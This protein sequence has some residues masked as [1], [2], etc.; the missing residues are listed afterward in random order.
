M[1]WEQGT[2]QIRGQTIHVSKGA[3]GQQLSVEV[4]ILKAKALIDGLRQFRL[5]TASYIAIKASIKRMAVS[6]AFV[7]G[8]GDDRGSRFAAKMNWRC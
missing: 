8:W 5:Q 4:F 2:H 1:R 6:C 7:V 3:G